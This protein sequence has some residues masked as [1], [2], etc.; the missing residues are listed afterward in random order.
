M[1]SLLF[2][3]FAPN[4]LA[5]SCSVL[6]LLRRR[7]WGHP[8]LWGLS[9]KL[10]LKSGSH[11]MLW[12]WGLLPSAQPHWGVIGLCEALSR[13]T[14]VPIGSEPPSSA[15]GIHRA[16]AGWMRTAPGQGLLSHPTRG[17]GELGLDP[18]KPL[19][20]QGLGALVSPPCVS[21]SARPFR[22][23]GL[24]EALMR[25]PGLGK[26]GP[27]GGGHPGHRSLE[28]LSLPAT[29]CWR[30]TRWDSL[31]GWRQ[32]WSPHAGWWEGTVYCAQGDALP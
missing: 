19:E 3:L 27:Q 9:L 10:C 17:G 22:S 2:G 18:A 28:S 11:L 25:C 29:P 26:G 13:P 16:G 12:G 6:F 8:A 4:A 7:P 32:I 21:P 30:G 24:S 15:G 14:S 23:F 31:A 20:S 5:R 1:E